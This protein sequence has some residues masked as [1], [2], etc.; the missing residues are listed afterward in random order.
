MMTKTPDD[1]GICRFAT[2]YSGYV[3][4]QNQEPDQFLFSVQL[5]S[6][7]KHGKRVAFISIAI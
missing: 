7:G 5:F 1:P 2:T 3:F 4:S 6:G